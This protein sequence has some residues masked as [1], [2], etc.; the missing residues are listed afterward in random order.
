MR[1]H[2][3]GVVAAVS[4]SL[5]I[6][7]A[8]AASV[9]SVP[10]TWR[11][12][13]GAQPP[14]ADSSAYYIV[15]FKDAPAATYTGGV[16]GYAAT[17]ARLRGTGILDVTGAA[18]YVAYL[19]ERQSVLLDA[20]SK[21]L[22]RT[23]SVRYRYHL[24]INGMSL[25]LTPA[26]AQRLAALPGV[27]SVQPV[28]HFRPDAA[29]VNMP[30]TAGDTNA[31][32]AWINAPTVWQLPTNGT[33]NEGEG[34]VLADLDTG[35]NDANSS[36]AAT[37][38]ADSYAAQNPGGRHF[39]VCDPSNSS[40]HSLST[41]LVCNDKLIGA[42]SY[43]HGANDPNSPEDSEGH[44]S[45]T[46]S[47]VAG[48]FTTTTV[49]S[50]STPLSGVAPHASIIAYDVCDP[51][52]LCSEDDSVAAVEQ[53]IKD[54]AAI[55]SAW[56]TSFKGMVL[57]FSIGS[58]DDP[59]SDVVEQ[60]FL[61]AVEAGIYVSAAGG[62]GGPSNVIVHDPKNAPV[63]AVQHMGPWLT[64]NAAATHDGTFSPNLLENFSGGDASTLPHI[65]MSGAGDTAGFG[66][67]PL[68]YT[69]SHAFDGDDPPKTGNAP[70][71]QSPYPASQGSA[72]DADQCLFPFTAGTFTHTE[73]VVCDRGTNPLVDKAYNVMKGGAKGMVIASTATSSQDAPVESYVIPATLLDQTNGNKLRAWLNASAIG[74]PQAQISGSTLTTDSSQADH[75][76]GFSSRGPVGSV[77]D[78][79][80]KPDVTAPGVSVLAAVSN[81]KYTEGCNGCNDLP[82]TFD[83]FDGTSMS[84]PHDTG[85]AALLKQAHPSWTPAEMKSALMLTAVTT[86][87]GTSPGLTDQCA[88]LDSGENCVASS[89]LPSPQVRGSGRID[90]D[91]AE[92][93]GLV[94]DETGAHY[95]AANP[96]NGG[97]LTTLNLASLGNV[98][99]ITTCTWT[100][101]V[102]SAFTSTS[103][104]YSVS[105]S[106][107]TGGLLVSVSPSAFTL[108]AGKSRTLTIRA[109][110]SGVAQNKWAFGEADITASGTGDGGEAIPPMHLPVAVQSIL[111]APHMNIDP[112]SLTYNVGS[113]G[114][115]S[116]NFTISNDGQKPLVWSLE[117]DGGQS[118]GG[119]ACNNHGMA[120]LSMSQK[121]G[122]VQPGKSS[123]VTATF[124]PGNQGTGTFSGV[125]CVSGN[126]SDNAS[127]TISVQA[128]VTGGS[129]GGELGLVELSLLGLLLR[130]RMRQ[131]GS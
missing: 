119:F 63:Y 98:A 113:G 108:A 51:T 48:D 60:A 30:A 128:S 74:S 46:A 127:L 76:A 66:P 70:T 31:S 83:F 3:I 40:Q 39:G 32:R 47:T 82:E 67:E 18:S 110:S 10:H 59:Y 25:K 114:S 1:S 81:P 129:G 69:G 24:A 28:R 89:S 34:I 64:T 71:S 75:I 126:A 107:L 5:L 85:A 97:N 105:V 106:G 115:S 80:V 96:A 43:T 35:I 53:A 72:A 123:T 100:R 22:G 13:S 122:T 86:A 120:G 38:L 7:I 33:D 12:A 101:T 8:Q 17:S 95:A 42:Y 84:T 131:A 124:A 103:V 94:M 26:E 2:Y 19:D 90:V 52:D 104:P 45:H 65:N 20:G 91:A 36:F 92:R 50:V 6:G 88:S 78:S 11:L 118:N 15:R 21:L 79:L 102:T 121:S 62:N 58:S 73:I 56:G 68:V 99:C 87:N 109:D 57:N 37:A 41:P 14:A 9:D 27:V 54:Q 112:L 130:R 16:A 23:L 49:N 125:I 93:T 44:G 111:P 117:T 77:F 29:S 55:K 4:L 116:Q 61:S